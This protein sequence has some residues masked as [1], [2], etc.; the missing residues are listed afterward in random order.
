MGR[1]W[2]IRLVGRVDKWGAKKWCLLDLL[3][4]GTSSNF[5]HAHGS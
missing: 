5:K 3:E 2:E 1:R 4:R